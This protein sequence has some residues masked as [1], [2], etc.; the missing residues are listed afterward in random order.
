MDHESTQPEQANE[1]P[2]DATV[3]RQVQYAWLWSSMPWLA[4]LGVIYYMDWIVEPVP[5]V[6]AVIS[7]IILAPRYLSW[8]RTAYIVTKEL[9]IYQRGGLTGARRYDLA[10]SN[11]SDAK[12]RY[13]FFGRSLGYQTIEIKLKNGAVANLT[14]VP[15]LEDVAK[16][17][18][19]LIAA[20]GTGPDEGQDENEKPEDSPSAE[21]DGTSQDDSSTE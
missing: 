21:P 19:E 12:A 5:I 15:I 13:G 10:I 7:V 20:S 14:Y 2:E 16:I 8:R 11:L 3:I 4:V 1:I 6:G 18:R 9:L 17:L